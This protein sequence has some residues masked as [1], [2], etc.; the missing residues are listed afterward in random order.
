[1]NLVNNQK[2]YE[3]V[4]AGYD[5]IRDRKLDIPFGDYEVGSLDSTEIDFDANDYVGRIIT[6]T[7]P[8]WQF[9]TSDLKVYSSKP[10]EVVITREDGIYYAENESLEIYASGNS[11]S[12]EGG[13]T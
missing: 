11:E 6:K 1:M 2:I 8:K 7:T 12:S 10:I 9:I 5:L 4:E 3:D 13:K